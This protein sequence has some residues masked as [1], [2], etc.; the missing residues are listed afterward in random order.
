MDEIHDQSIFIS[1]CVIQIHELENGIEF[2]HLS[3]VSSRS[4]VPKILLWLLMRGKSNVEALYRIKRSKNSL[5]FKHFRP[6]CD[7]SASL[8]TLPAVFKFIGLI[9]LDDTRREV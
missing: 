7:I 1:L 6:R 9:S 3:N 2:T 4:K 8:W 5:E